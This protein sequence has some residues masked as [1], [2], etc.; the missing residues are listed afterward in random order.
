MWRSF[1]H[2]GFLLSVFLSFILILVILHP[3]KFHRRDVARRA[4]ALSL[5]QRAYDEYSLRNMNHSTVP[6]IHLTMES[7]KPKRMLLLR[8]L[9]DPSPANGPHQVCVATYGSLRDIYHAV[10]LSWLWK[11]SP[12]SVALFAGDGE[13][14]LVL[15][16]LQ[17]LS[18]CHRGI[19]SHFDFSLLVANSDDLWQSENEAFYS[20][21]DCEEYKEAL[22]YQLSRRLKPATASAEAESRS[23]LR[24]RPG[25]IPENELKN[26]AQ[27]GCERLQ[28]KR[29]LTL[30][31]GTMPKP[32]L[33]IELASFLR[34]LPCEKCI[35]VLP[36]FLSAQ[37]Q[38]VP[39]SKSALDA[40]VSQKRLLPVD[41]ATYRLWELFNE[42]S[43]TLAFEPKPR[44]FPA[45]VA[46]LDL[47]KLDIRFKGQDATNTQLI[48]AYLIGYRFWVLSDGFVVR[49]IFGHRTP[50][51]TDLAG[52]SERRKRTQTASDLSAAEE[53]KNELRGKYP[54]VEEIHWS[55]DYLQLKEKQ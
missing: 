11:A 48:E 21:F 45:Y 36:S 5:R 1:S 50:K 19:K 49:K 29:A 27:S 18:S 10:E 7:S 2:A 39:R 47:P 6:L 51:S 9:N 38:K 54:F 22:T 24:S 26:I 40:L 15:E 28:V 33:D 41:N 14:H 44:L 13:A 30:P 16:Y 32:R 43:M 12:V 23:E 31:L 25:P 4:L 42:E 55:N 53:F 20:K 37:N 35:L 52:Q 17:Y 8:D 34:S 3:G 46:P